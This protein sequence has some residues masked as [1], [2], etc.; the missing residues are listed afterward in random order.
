MRSPHH[1]VELRAR[2]SIS[3]PSE[4]PT[5]TTPVVPTPSPHRSQRWITWWIES[6]FDAMVTR[7]LAGRPAR[8]DAESVDVTVVNPAAFAAG[9]RV[10]CGRYEKSRFLP[11]AVPETRT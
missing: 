9:R 5:S 3:E 4:W 11:Y 6:A 10:V 8:A 1:V 7:S 2:T